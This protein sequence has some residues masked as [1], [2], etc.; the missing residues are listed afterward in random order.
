MTRR[1]EP[2]YICLCLLSENYDRLGP[3]RT[4]RG[5]PDERSKKK[6]AKLS[7][8]LSNIQKKKKNLSYFGA[9]PLEQ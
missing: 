8:Q 5:R 9:A 4:L 3:W 6:A 1:E 7:R 2:L